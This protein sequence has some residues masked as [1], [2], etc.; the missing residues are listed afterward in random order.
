MIDTL[1]RIDTTGVEPLVYLNDIPNPTR[2][3]DVKNQL[4]K[5]EALSNAPQKN[6]DFIT[7]PKVIDL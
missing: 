1:E 7:I 3:D 6:D 5:Q 4:A 2:S